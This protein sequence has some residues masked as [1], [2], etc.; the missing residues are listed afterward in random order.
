MQKILIAGASGFIGR[1]LIK[2]LESQN[3]LEVVALSREDKSSPHSRLTWKKADLFS[4]KDISEAMEGCDQAVY[5]VHSMLPSAS[6]V[7]GTFYDM[8]L[9]LADNFA[10]AA[11]A[12]GIKHV[13]YLGGLL[14]LEQQNLSWHLKSRLE[15]EQ[16]LQGCAPKVTILRAG[17]VLGREGSSFTIMRRLVER[18]PVMLCPRWTS[19][20]SHPIDLEDLLKVFLCTLTDESVQGEVWDVGG[21]REMTYLDMMKTAAT[22]LG[23]RPIIIPVWAFSPKFSRFWVTLVTGAPRALVYPLVLSLRHPML[24]RKDRA[25]PRKDLMKTSFEDSLKRLVP[26][27]EGDVHAFHTPVVL[28]APK[29]VRSVQ[30]LLLPNNKNAQWVADEYF[31][32]LP[33]FFSFI[34]RIKV[35]GTLCR[36]YLLHPKLTLLLLDK[37]IERSSPD[38]Q[39]LYIRGGLLAK[40]ADRGRLEF[41]EVLDKNYILAAIHDFRPRLPWIIYKWT[42]A[43]VHLIVMHSFGAHLRKIEKLQKDKS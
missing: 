12:K 25:F 40:R 17:M 24:M 10:R 35:E 39:L 36:F 21:P 8:D 32:W 5:L 14:P 6:L 33:R 22:S 1:A 20:R 34:I 18:L 43:V 19:T 13:V 16:C 7:Q 31:L 29:H 37:S 2:S 38:R 15:V 30:R 9:I 27:D 26:Q 42:Q 4:L 28:K 11:K 41:R 3:S 23:K